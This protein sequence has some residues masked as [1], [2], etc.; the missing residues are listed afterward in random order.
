M[1][2]DIYVSEH[3]VYSMET[4]AKETGHED[5]LPNLGTH[6]IHA[7]LFWKNGLELR[8]GNY[9]ARMFQCI[10]RKLLELLWTSED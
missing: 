6:V 4:A 1:Q 10:H 8:Q 7:I 9:M 2:F 3:I 5:Y